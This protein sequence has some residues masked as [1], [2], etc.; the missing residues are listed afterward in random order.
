MGVERGSRYF[1]LPAVTC[2]NDVPSTSSLAMPPSGL[3]PPPSISRAFCQPARAKGPR[4]HRPRASEP[5]VGSSKRTSSAPGARDETLTARPLRTTS[6]FPAA[7]PASGQV[8]I[9][10][11]QAPR[12]SVRRPIDP[13]FRSQSSSPP[14]GLPRPCH[15]TA[16]QLEQVTLLAFRCVS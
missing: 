5:T 8:A 13:V 12:G 2:K 16:F 1:H 10:V 14:P 4:P 15:R 11:S 7:S 3:E 9:R 6:T